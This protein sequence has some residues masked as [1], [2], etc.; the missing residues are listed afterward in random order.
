MGNFAAVLV[1]IACP[2][3]GT[4]CVNE[5]VRVISYDSAMSCTAQREDE[6]R[7]I[8]IPGFKIYG[9]CNSV[10]GDLLAG[11]P[12]I[13]IKRPVEKPETRPLE[14]EGSAPVR[15]RAFF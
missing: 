7:K 2:A 15:R 14:N 8:N 1:L 9:E 10:N 5:P 11:R 4:S 6:I 13:D 3:S 12:R